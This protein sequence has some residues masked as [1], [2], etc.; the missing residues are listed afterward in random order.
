MRIRPTLTACETLKANFGLKWMGGVAQEIYS[1]CQAESFF[2]ISV[3][4]LVKGEFDDQHQADTGDKRDEV[5]GVFFQVTVF[6]DLGHQVRG[7]DIEKIA[8]SERN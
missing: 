2:F 5:N 6:A 7:G 3:A 8:C 4:S 1:Y